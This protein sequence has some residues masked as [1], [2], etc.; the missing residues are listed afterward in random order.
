MHRIISLSYLF[1]IAYGMKGFKN[2]PALCER[3]YFVKIG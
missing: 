2:K 3:A 1:I